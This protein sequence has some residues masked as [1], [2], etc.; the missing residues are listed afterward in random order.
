MYLETTGSEKHGGAGGGGAQRSGVALVF[1]INNTI[2]F[3]G[4]V[5][6]YLTVFRA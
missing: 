6:V 5:G 2:F 1:G 3:W 4:M